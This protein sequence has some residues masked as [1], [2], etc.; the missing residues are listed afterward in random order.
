MSE[1]TETTKPE[2]R[3]TAKDE[4]L[5]V[6]LPADEVEIEVCRGWWDE[7]YPKSKARL[8]SE[9]RL[10][11]LT[12]EHVLV[13]LTR[14]PPERPKFQRMEGG[15]REALPSDM[16][17]RVGAPIRVKDFWSET[18]EDGQVDY[19][20]LVRAVGAQVVPLRPVF[21]ADDLTLRLLI[22]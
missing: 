7:K 8:I 21:R 13:T 1:S 20:A 11:R 4:N 15:L 2:L 18:G 9:L 6:L 22:S 19:L 17:V 14:S 3:T 16:P 5:Y 10:Q 12:D